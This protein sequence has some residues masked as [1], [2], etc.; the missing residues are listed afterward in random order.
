MVIIPV[1]ADIDVFKAKRTS[2]LMAKDSGF[3]ASDCALIEIAVSELATNIIKHAVEGTIT[4]DSIQGGLEIVSED[5]GAGVADIEGAL[6]GGKSSKGLGI[7]L[8]GVK[9]MMDQIEISS[10]RGNG[11]RI[12]VR[13]WK[14]KPAHLIRSKQEYTIPRGGLMKYGVISVPAL[15]LEFNGDAYVIKELGRKVLMAVID[16]LGHGEK[17][18]MVAQEAADYVQKSYTHDLASIVEGCHEVLRRT[19]GVV[20]GLVR[21]DLEESRLTTAGVGNIGM[22]AEGKNPMRSFSAA[23]IVGN[24]FKKLMVQEFPYSRGDTIFLHSD[25][26]SQKFD[27]EVLDLKGME[28]QEIAEAVARR[29]G[30]DQDDTTVVVA[31]EG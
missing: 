28:P 3:N 30:K 16:G 17:A 7:G 1:S 4:I 8:S 14:V 23:G 15:G 31:R 10:S 13:K 9:R 12:V 20:M 21:V 22:R 27:P 18:Y 19:R 11:A 2:R 24:N 26:V 29:F 25:G 6:K 5:R